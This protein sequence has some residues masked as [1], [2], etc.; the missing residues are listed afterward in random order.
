M[1]ILFLA[2]QDYLISK[3]LPSTGYI[4]MWNN[5]EEYLQAGTDEQYQLPALFIEFP[6]EIEYNQLGNGVQTVDDLRVKIHILQDF[7]DT[8]TGAMSQNLDVLLM[9][10]N[11]YLAFQEWMPTTVTIPNTGI[12]SD[13]AGT[14]NVPVGVMSRRKEY[15]DKDHDNIYHFVQEYSTTWVDKDLVRPVGG[16]L[17]VPV[18][19]YNLDL[20]SAWDDTALYLVDAY[21]SYSGFIYQCIL[22]TTVAHEVPTNTT[23]WKQ[24][25]A[26]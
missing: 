2:I 24:I 22:N 14:Y 3:G 7:Y 21:V 19:D 17:S 18:L 16:V 12:Y 11:I 20:I 25:Q 8:K 23:Y 1:Y 4:R 9:A 13:Y 10:Q 15:E 6:D 5:N 26:I